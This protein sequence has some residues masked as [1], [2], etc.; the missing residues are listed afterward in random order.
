MALLLSLVM[1]LSLVPTT[2]WA[3]GASSGDVVDNGIATQAS[4]SWTWTVTIFGDNYYKSD[5]TKSNTNRYTT[6]KSLDNSKDNEIGYKFEWN[7]SAGGRVYKGGWQLCITVNGAVVE[8]TTAYV[9]TRDMS[10]ASGSWTAPGSSHTGTSSHP[11]T[12]YLSS[13]PKETSNCNHDYDWKDNG[14]GTHTGT[15]KNCND[16]VTE[17]HNDGNGD[18]FC[19]KCG[20]C[21]HDKDNKGYCTVKDCQHIKDGKSCCQKENPAP[22]EPADPKVGENFD[23]SENIVDVICKTNNNH[24]DSYGLMNGY[25]SVSNKT[26]LSNGNWQ[27]ALTINLK[28]YFNLYN[29]QHSGLTHTREKGTDEFM[30]IYP[31]CLLY[32]SPSP[33]D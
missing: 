31:T 25:Y 7:A 13:F 18:G 20:A 27:C 26:K 12:L 33:R 32:T 9:Y 15:C 16:K 6:N 3:A 5:G 17:G 11:F 19:D 23:F 29:S 14:D 10:T 21:L 24:N 2:V 22:T 30:T 1:A 28:E 8:R 4:M